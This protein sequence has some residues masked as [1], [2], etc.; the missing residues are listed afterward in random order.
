MSNLLARDANTITTGEETVESKAVGPTV[1]LP[2]RIGGVAV[3]A[4]VDTGSQS[5]IIS[6]SMLH[7]IGQHMVSQ[8]LMLPLLEK[9]T[10]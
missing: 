6:R 5:T 4:F 3:E 1:C 2:L 8:G 9:P 7:E 10:V